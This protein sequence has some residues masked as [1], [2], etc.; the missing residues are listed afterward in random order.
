MC[1][2]LIFY[3]IASLDLL[4]K[5]TDEPSLYMCATG[6]NS[7]CTV[8]MYSDLCCS[9]WSGPWWWSVVVTPAVTVRPRPVS[10]PDRWRAR[11]C[12]SA[13]GNTRE[14]ASPER[15]PPETPS[16]WR[17]FHT[18]PRSDRSPP[19]RLPSGANIQHR[20][21][22]CLWYLPWDRGSVRGQRF[23]AHQPG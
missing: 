1:G 8:Y 15:P 2:L 7:M 9:E 20:N 16:H 21:H 13:S 3:N 12:D 5:F 4:L 10:S 11:S 18:Q 22:I 19:P 6:L 17:R 23:T 14:P